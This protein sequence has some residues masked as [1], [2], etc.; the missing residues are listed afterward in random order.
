M[1]GGR[2]PICANLEPSL[3][4]GRELLKLGRPFSAR[5]L[6]PEE[7]LVVLL[8]VRK[9]HGVAEGESKGRGGD[10]EPSPP[11]RGKKA[12]RG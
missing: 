2:S 8:E 6:Q 3:H 5:L 4:E 12:L 1:R 10:T 11:V 7:D 9:R